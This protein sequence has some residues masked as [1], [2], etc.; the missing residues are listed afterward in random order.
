MIFELIA[1]SH[2][3]AAADAYRRFVPTERQLDALAEVG[4]DVLT[5]FPYVPG[6]CAM[7]SAM[8]A[9]RFQMNN[10][11]PVYVAAGELYLGASRVFGGA[12]HADASVFKESHPSWD[13]HCWIVFGDRI[14]DVSL[15][16]TAY[17]KSAPPRLAHY[18]KEHFGEG[19][20]LLIG[21]SETLREVDSLDY[22]PQYILTEAQITS[23]VAG[24][25]LLFQDRAAA[26]SVLAPPK[27]G[28]NDPCPCGSGRKF[29]KC[30]GA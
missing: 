29:K 9:A 4:R 5:H 28:R 8:Y 30:H 17:S 14:A 20:G 22:R 11:V 15:F 2:S 6:A 12:T 3:A 16:R 18:V 1:S 13:G 7:M 10:A 19:R 24:A 27:I 21:R 26:E 23:L 25:K